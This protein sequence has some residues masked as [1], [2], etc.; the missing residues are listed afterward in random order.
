MS[1]ILIDKREYM[2]KIYCFAY[3]KSNHPDPSQNNNFS[4]ATNLI[5]N[6]I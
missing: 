2:Q 1:N 4:Y 5:I 3:F 6:T